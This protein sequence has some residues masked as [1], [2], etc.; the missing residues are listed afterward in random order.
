MGEKDV[1]IFHFSS[2]FS[3]VILGLSHVWFNVFFLLR[4]KNTKRIIRCSTAGL[5][6]FFFSF[7]HKTEN[8]FPVRVCVWKLSPQTYTT[9]KKMV[10]FFVDVCICKACRACD[11]ITNICLWVCLVAEH[12]FWHKMTSRRVPYLSLLS[13]KINSNQRAYLVHVW[14]GVWMFESQPST[15]SQLESIEIEILFMT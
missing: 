10:R 12:Y 7:L 11:N 15:L 6:S 14:V 2:F 13:K 9:P 8:N 3:A 5:G 1:F 4:N